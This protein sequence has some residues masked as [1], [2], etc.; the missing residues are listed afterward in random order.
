M[1]PFFDAVMSWSKWDKGKEMELFHYKWT[2]NLLSADI[3]EKI[4]ELLDK[5]LMKP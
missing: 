2:M 1:F 5:A 4:W 3:T